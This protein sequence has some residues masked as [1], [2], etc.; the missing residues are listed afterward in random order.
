[1]EAEE[2]NKYAGLSKNINNF[3][4]SQIDWKI[5]TICTSLEAQAAIAT[6]IG[7]VK[8]QSFSSSWKLHGKS[9]ESLN[10]HEFDKGFFF[11]AYTFTQQQKFSLPLGFI[12]ALLLL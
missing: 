5:I 11:F 9:R 2:H 7:W 8:Q 1:M 6:C 4:S 10:V 3:L 12:R